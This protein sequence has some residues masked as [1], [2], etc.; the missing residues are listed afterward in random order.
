MQYVSFMHVQISSSVLTLNVQNKVR[1]VSMIRLAR[2]FSCK[3]HHIVNH[4]QYVYG[5]SKMHFFE[6]QVQT[7]LKT[8]FLVR[9]Q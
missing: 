2:L 7:F 9:F 3:S 6:G 4:M 8:F 5:D 1:F